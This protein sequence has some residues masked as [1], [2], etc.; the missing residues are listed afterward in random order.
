LI[1]K[2]SRLALG[3]Y[4]VPYATRRS[5]GASS[6]LA[7]GRP[8]LGVY[9]RTI[10]QRVEMT[11][12][13]GALR[14]GVSRESICSI[15]AGVRPRWGVYSGTIWKGVERP[16]SGGGWRTGG[17]RESICSIWGGVAAGS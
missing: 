2:V 7:A 4:L 13:R 17:G 15:W 12:S 5:L 9:S 10:W 16:A 3:K 6:V 1:G 11:A 14:T 8:P